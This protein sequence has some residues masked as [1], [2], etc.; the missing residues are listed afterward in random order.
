VTQIFHPRPFTI[1][2]VRK[3]KTREHR[4]MSTEL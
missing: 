2:L 1:S 3:Q 4:L